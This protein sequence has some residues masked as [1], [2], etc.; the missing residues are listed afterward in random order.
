VT[1]SALVKDGA[2]KRGLRPVRLR[3]DLGAIADLVELCFKDDLDASGRAALRE[4][5]TL[6]RTGP[7]L[8]LLAG[9]SRMIKGLASGFVWVENNVSIYRADVTQPTW[10]IA[11]VAVHPDYRRRGIARELMAASLDRLR[12]YG[13]PW[14]DLQ[15]K[16][17]NAAARTLYEGL[18]FYERTTWIT[19]RRPAQNAP[20]PVDA[21]QIKPARGG[22][23]RAMYELARVAR[24]VGLEWLRPVTP[25]AFKIGVMQRLGHLLAGSRCE[26]YIVPDA[27]DQARAALLVK[28]SAGRRADQLVM[29]THPAW[30]GSLERALLVFGLRRLRALGQQR[31]VVVQHFDQ[32]AANEALASL[33]FQRRDTL[34]HMRYNLA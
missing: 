30:R 7:L 4:M 2:E 27:G 31:A 9:L 28:A 10:V 32:P 6:S 20:P 24:P 26:R 15:V 1:A 3:T 22:A 16:R 13:A 19:W 25:G 12:G 29:I 21:D 23:W 17:D 5:R 11:N 8:W 34:V 14:V 33:G 18:G